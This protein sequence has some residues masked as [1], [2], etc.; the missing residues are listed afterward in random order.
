MFNT[1]AHGS[2]VSPGESARQTLDRNPHNAVIGAGLVAAGV[3]LQILSPSATLTCRRNASAPTSCVVTR[4]I[5]LG[6]V[7]IKTEPIPGLRRARVVEVS[8]EH[9]WFRR[10]YEV[11]LD[12]AE[13]ERRMT[14]TGNVYTAIDLGQAINAGLAT[15][16]PT[17]EAWLGFAFEDVPRRGAG[18]VGIV[19]GIGSL[20]GGLLRSRRARAGSVQTP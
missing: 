18:L 19:M 6:M 10:K 4:S 13:G 2:D 14:T 9:I 1:S 12:T 11:T 17:F 5:L 3:I 20:V 15:Q 16:A 7:P 8:I